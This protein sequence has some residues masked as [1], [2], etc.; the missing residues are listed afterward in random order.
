M[1]GFFKRIFRIGK[2]EASALLDNLEDPIRMTEQGI[3][4][5]KTDLDKS[6]QSLAEVKAI[7]IRTR[8]ESETQKQLV[9]DYETKARALLTRAK[10]GQI[11]LEEAKRLAGEALSRKEEVGRQQALSVT[12]SAKYDAM[13]TN[14][15]GK[16]NQLKSQ[17]ASW[18][19]EL[20]TL[21]ARHKVST[22]TTK[23]NK[24]MAQVDSNDTVALLE[25]MKEKVEEKEALAEAY[26]DI[27]SVEKSVDVEI[28]K[29]L[30]GAKPSADLDNLL[31]E[32]GMLPEK[33]S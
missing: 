5:L 30:E 12:N 28:N 26:G 2:A 3:T 1:L 22:A 6:I 21:K 20:R 18:E 23:I 25:R 16:I 13:V 32:M 24:Q 4:E 11:E 17:I 19:N 31:A 9:A 7:A 33:T 27:A 10:D 29:A 8:R 15:E 14:L